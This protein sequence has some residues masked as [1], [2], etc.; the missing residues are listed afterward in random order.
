VIV[1]LRD[2]K[3]IFAAV[4]CIIWFAILPEEEDEDWQGIT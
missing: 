3:T 2:I 4:I 1:N